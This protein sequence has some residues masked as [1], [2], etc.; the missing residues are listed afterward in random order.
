MTKNKH[1]TG[2]F[3]LGLLAALLSAPNG[4]FI[5]LAGDELDPFVLNSLRFILISL[6]VLPYVLHV[7]NKIN[8]KNLRYSVLMGIWMTVAAMSYV[9]AI[10][11]SQASYVAIIS[12]GMPIVFILYSIAM[13][14]EKVTARSIAGVSVAALGAFVVVA[15]PIILEGGVSGG[16]NIWA[17]IFALVDVFAFPLAIIYS[18]KANEAGLPLM[19]SFGISSIIVAT[20]T[21]ACAM[22]VAGVAAY[23]AAYNPQSIIAI[24]YSAIAVAL[25]ARLLNVVSYERLGSV[26]TA[27]LSYVENLLA[28]ALP[29]L[30][31]GEVIT[32]ELAIGGVLILIGVSIAET[33]HRTRQHRHIRVMQHR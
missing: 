32:I 11:L 27:G 5:K 18:R 22:A 9:A 2:W 16:Q 15:L 21:T 29:L 12:L 19:A 26:V 14:R 31:L 28:V 33:Q 25:I 10:S 30:I 8:K 1:I 7:R 17:T 4:I 13:T 24:V 6:V 20:V 23:E 3:L